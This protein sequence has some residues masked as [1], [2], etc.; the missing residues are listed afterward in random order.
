MDAAIREDLLN[1][2]Y[3]LVDEGV[4]LIARGAVLP[5][6]DVKRIV[7]IGFVVRTGVQVHRKQPLW[8]HARGRRIELQFPDRNA[9]AVGA[10]VAQAQDAAGIGY[11]DEA[12]V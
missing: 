12:H 7:E 2:L 10:Q 11:T 3:E 6:T 9:H 1:R 5:Q 4:Q 8:W